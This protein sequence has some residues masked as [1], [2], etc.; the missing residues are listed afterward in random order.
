MWSHI[1]IKLLFALRV[2][3]FYV[4]Q[5]RPEYGLVAETRSYQCEIKYVVF[6]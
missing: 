6:M 4:M 3:L 5:K 1:K 2:A